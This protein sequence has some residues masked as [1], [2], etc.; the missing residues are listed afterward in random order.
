VNGLS[1]ELFL[2][3]I[4]FEDENALFCSEMF[5]FAIALY[6]STNCSECICLPVMYMT[7]DHSG[8][9]NVF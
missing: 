2:N 5:N 3:T 4:A 8:C 9:K 6:R 7:Y 1:V